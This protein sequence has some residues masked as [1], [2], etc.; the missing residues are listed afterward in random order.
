MVMLF[1]A[2]L[3]LSFSPLLG[4]L[5]F[6]GYF[7]LEAGVAL[8]LGTVI[9]KPS[10][11]AK[12]FHEHALVLAIPGILSGALL[13]AVAR[14]CNNEAMLPISMVIVPSLFYLVLI[15]HGYSISDAREGGWVG[16]ESPPV[17]VRDLFNL[18]DFGRVR[19]DVGKELIPTWA[20]TYDPHTDLS[21]AFISYQVDLF[22]L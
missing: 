8:C 22:H 19:W 5:A 9:M 13:T 16:A 14:K 2:I 1:L 3:P 7:C 6:I 21:V 15:F 10:D 4:Y 18:I 20:G 12:L 17:P 11:W